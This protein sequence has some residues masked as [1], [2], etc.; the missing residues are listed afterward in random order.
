MKMRRK[1]NSGTTTRWERKRGR[2]KEKTIDKHK[3][4]DEEKVV[5]PIQLYFL[6]SGIIRGFIDILIVIKSSC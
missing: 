2:I 5:G 3:M 1:R 4:S 6:A